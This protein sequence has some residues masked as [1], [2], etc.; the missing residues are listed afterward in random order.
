MTSAGDSGMR[1][2]DKPS[3]RM[4][5]SAAN[6]SKT[7]VVPSVPAAKKRRYA[8]IDLP[9]SMASV[10]DVRVLHQKT[11]MSFALQSSLNREEATW[12]AQG[13]TTLFL[14]TPHPPTQPLSESSTVPLALHL[15]GSCQVSQV[16]VQTLT[17]TKKSARAKAADSADFLS[18]R[19]P[20]AACIGQTAIVVHFRR[21][22]QERVSI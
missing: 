7:E 22:S 8:P 17:W 11:S 16:H 9:L 12:H 1:K 14:T 4:N 19:G 15:R 20:V 18:S 6:L 2:N 3:L 10:S 5:L 21:G 13:T